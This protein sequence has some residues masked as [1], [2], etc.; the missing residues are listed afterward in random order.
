M[1]KNTF[2]I[3]V[4]DPTLTHNSLFSLFFSMVSLLHNATALFPKSHNIQ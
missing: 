2:T 4:T 3:F 1:Y